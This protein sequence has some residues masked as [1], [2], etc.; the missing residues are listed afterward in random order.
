[1]TGDPRIIRGYRRADTLSAGQA[2]CNAGYID[3]PGFTSNHYHCPACGGITGMTGH[4]Q[5]K[6]RPLIC[7]EDG[8]NI[9]GLDD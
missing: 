8:V 3:C 4:Y 7:A 6:D 1:V 9:V 2:V 5:G